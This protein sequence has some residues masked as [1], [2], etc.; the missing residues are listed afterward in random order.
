MDRALRVTSQ[1]APVVLR[2]DLPRDRAAT[3][4]SDEHARI[5]RRALPHVMEYNQH[6]FSTTDVG[7]WP[8]TGMVGTISPEDYD[9]I[10]ELRFAGVVGAVRN[11]PHSKA[12]YSTSRT[13]SRP[14]SATRPA[15]L[16][17]GGGP[18]DSTTASGIGP[19]S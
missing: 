1:I 18:N 12:V 4:W 6:H 2:A 11:I 8:A 10:A 5:V 19:S 7:Y 14:S 15:S 3:Y 16:E 17:G 13:P 9:G